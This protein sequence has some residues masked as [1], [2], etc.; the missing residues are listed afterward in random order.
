VIIDHDHEWSF[1]S[2]GGRTPHRCGTVTT[3]CC[4][5]AVCGAACGTAPVPQ[6]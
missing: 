6:R 4:T 3:V 2:R 5:A 1:P